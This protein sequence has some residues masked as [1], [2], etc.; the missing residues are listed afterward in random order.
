MFDLLKNNIIKINQ[1]LDNNLNYTMHISQCQNIKNVYTQ[2]ILYLDI[3]ISDLEN[4]NVFID[5]IV[6]LVCKM[7]P[8]KNKTFVLHV[9]NNL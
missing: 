1:Y 2:F 7:I 8:T 3:L 9:F 6:L 5:N 4:V